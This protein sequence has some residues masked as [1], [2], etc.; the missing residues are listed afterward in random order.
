MPARTRHLTSADRTTIDVA[1]QVLRAAVNS[2]RT[3]KVDTIPVRLALRVLL[4]HCPERWPLVN[5]WE[6]ASSE[7]PIFRGQNVSA[8][9]NAI[10]IQL[11][12]SGVWRA[13]AP[14]SPPTA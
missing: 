4:P 7:D 8:A 9:F 6:F 14:D 5:L 12:K 2:S 3:E 10:V 13:P 1:V 11:G